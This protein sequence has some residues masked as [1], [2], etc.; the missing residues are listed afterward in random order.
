M[1]RA[2]SVSLNTAPRGH[3][4]GAASADARSDGTNALDICHSD[5][6]DDEES[7]DSDGPVSKVTRVQA[8][9]QFV[10]FNL[11]SSYLTAHYPYVERQG[12]TL[13][14]RIM[15][16]KTLLGEPIR[17]GAVIA[18]QEIDHVTYQCLM[19]WFAA[20]NYTII[21]SNYGFKFPG[22]M[23]TALAFPTTEFTITADG[24][25][26]DYPFKHIPRPP[27]PSIVARIAAW[28]LPKR[29]SEYIFPPHP[30]SVAKTYH[31]ALVGL[32][33]R[34][35]ESGIDIAV[36]NYHMP[37]A[38][39][40][41]TIMTAHARAVLDIINLRAR[42]VPTVLMGDLNAGP[43]SPAIHTLRTNF[44]TMPHHTIRE[45]SRSMSVRKTEQWSGLIDWILTRQTMN[46]SATFQDLRVI[47]ADHEGIL[48]LMPNHD[49][50]SDH[51]PVSAII[52][53]MSPA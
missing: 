35:N 4:A 8:H 37:C 49:M 43:Q 23:G 29:A 30:L 26:V 39:H 6:E 46:T 33:L 44:T 16:M 2:R 51:A 13:R 38:W 7:Q 53:F 36:F 20:N 21:C 5:F 19:P 34:H 42:D 9:L 52:R 27:R 15:C 17:N 50:P 14:Q 1:L 31:N 28:L 18:L 22:G 40:T 47:G 45:T 24:V 25:V 3:R 32:K 11:L 10:T 48:P 41:P 12:I